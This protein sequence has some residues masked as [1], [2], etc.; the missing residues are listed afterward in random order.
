MS[1]SNPTD[2]LVPS[3]DNVNVTYRYIGRTNAEVSGNLVVGKS[4]G[5]MIEYLEGDDR[6]RSETGHVLEQMQHCNLTWVIYNAGNQIPGG[7]VVNDYSG[8]S[9]SV[10]YVIRSTSINDTDTPAG[11]YDTNAA[12][13]FISGTINKLKV[14]EMEMLV[15]TWEIDPMKWSYK[16]DVK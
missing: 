14:T 7:A 5:R 16:Y 1:A 2:S 8:D 3:T 11:Y 15:V 10:L 6:G 9:S 13:G 12:T 4:N